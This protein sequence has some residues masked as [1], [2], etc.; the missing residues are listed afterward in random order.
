MFDQNSLKFKY[1]PEVWGA[2]AAGARAC[3]KDNVPASSEATSAQRKCSGA[4]SEASAKSRFS[5]FENLWFFPNESSPTIP[6]ATTFIHFMYAL[7]KTVVI[8]NARWNVSD[9]L[10]SIQALFKKLFSLI[11]FKSKFKMTQ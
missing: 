7:V 10:F 5:R 8:F 9:F 6:L 4:D 2:D 1:W 11:R 3:L